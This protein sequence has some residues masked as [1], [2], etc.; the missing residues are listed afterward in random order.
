MKISKFTPI[1]V[2]S[3]PAHLEPGL[4]YI[5]IKYHTVL[6]LCPCGC[7][8]EIV[9]PIA[10]DQWHLEWDGESVSLS[11]SVGNYRLACRSHY[12]IRND[13]VEWVPER[14]EN[15]KV[16]FPFMKTLIIKKKRKKKK[17]KRG[18]QHEN[19]RLSP[20]IRTANKI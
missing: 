7:G 5:S 16:K 19:V 9:T 17:D 12:F 15:K 8:E 6:H 14:R 18:K 4:L 2:E 11:P 10:R 1:I 13:R 3:A 20:G